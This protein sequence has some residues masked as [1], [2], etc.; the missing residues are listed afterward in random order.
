MKIDSAVQQEMFRAIR[1]FLPFP[2]A[3]PSCAS[4]P[5]ANGNRC[6]KKATTCDDL[7]TIE[8]SER[9]TTP[10]RRNVNSSVTVYFLFLTYLQAKVGLSR[11][12]VKTRQKVSVAAAADKMIQDQ[13]TLKWLIQNVSCLICCVFG[14]C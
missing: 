5:F 8:F 4:G 7:S 6:G 12:K 2:A 3:L 11:R 14:F 1:G 9:I 13:E 10:I